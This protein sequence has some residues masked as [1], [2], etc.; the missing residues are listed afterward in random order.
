[1]ARNSKSETFFHQPCLGLDLD[2]RVS[3]DELFRFSTLSLSPILYRNGCS[4][5]SNSSNNCG[6]CYLFQPDAPRRCR[7]RRRRRHSHCRR[8]RLSVPNQVM[9]LWRLL[10]LQLLLLEPP[11]SPHFGIDCCFPLVLEAAQRDLA[12]SSDATK[13]FV[14]AVVVPSFLFT[15]FAPNAPEKNRSAN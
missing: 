9:L 5:N 10:L 3:R 12:N 13:V 15:A 1:M 2:E 14:V 8:R 4:N 11:S 7:R 6:Q